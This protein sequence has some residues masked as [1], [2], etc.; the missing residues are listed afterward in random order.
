MDNIRKIKEEFSKYFI[1]LF[2]VIAAYMVFLV[3]NPFIITILTSIIISYIFYPLYKWINKKTR[4]KNL[5][6]IIVTILIIVLIITPILFIVNSLTR[7]VTTVYINSKQRIAEGNIIGIGF[8]SNVLW[9]LNSFLVNIA[10]KPQISSSLDNIIN[11]IISSALKGKDSTLISSQIDM[12]S[13]Y[14]KLKQELRKKVRN[15]LELIQELIQELT[16]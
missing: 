2:F 15:V 1:L 8:D 11:T 4:R 3:I 7:E 6:A 14:L 10:E 5:S 9:K 13:L 12:F 16:H